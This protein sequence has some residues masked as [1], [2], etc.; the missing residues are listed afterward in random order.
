MP[1]TTVK[2]VMTSVVEATAAGA[3]RLLET[4]K[5]GCLPVVEHGRLVGLVTEADFV[6]FARHYFEWEMGSSR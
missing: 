6:R 5:L 3:A 1:T 2:E 4:H